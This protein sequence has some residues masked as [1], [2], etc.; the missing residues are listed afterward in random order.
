MVYFF[1]LN[2]KTTF[3]V[4]RQDNVYLAP[5]SDMK[6]PNGSISQI[7]KHTH[8]LRS[9]SFIFYISSMA[10][11]FS[12]LPF[13]LFLSHFILTYANPMDCIFNLLLSF[14][15]FGSKN[16]DDR[17]CHSAMYLKVF[18]KQENGSYNL[19]TRVFYGLFFDIGDNTRGKCLLYT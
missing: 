19:S 10:L 15:R 5:Y 18:P 14:S 6:Y 3:R 7:K 4:T 8:T 11:H 1:L 12:F 2:T 13:P 9:G 17:K 16:C